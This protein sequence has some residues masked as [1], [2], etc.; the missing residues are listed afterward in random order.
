MLVSGI[1]KADVVEQFQENGVVPDVLDK[2]PPKLL[3]VSHHF[4][5]QQDLKNQ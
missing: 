3:K 5:L 4:H 1:V 2:A